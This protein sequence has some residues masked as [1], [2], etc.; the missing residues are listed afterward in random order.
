MKPEH[1]ST[2]YCGTKLMFSQVQVMPSKHQRAGSEMGQ[3]RCTHV[4]R[5][6]FKCPY[7]KVQEATVSFSPMET[8]QVAGSHRQTTDVWL[9]DLGLSSF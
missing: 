4:V 3:L 7:K 6:I 1:G 9:S 5:W 8:Q 2:P